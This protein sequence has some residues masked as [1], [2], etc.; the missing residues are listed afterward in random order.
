MTVAANS[1]GWR[2]QALRWL[3]HSAGLFAT[4]MALF[5]L[6]D[7]ETAPLV[8]A[9]G[10]LAYISVWLVVLYLRDRRGPRLPF[11]IGLLQSLYGLSV[12][13]A[14]FGLL[15]LSIVE[16]TI[17]AYL[18]ITGGAEIWNGSMIG[19]IA[20]AAAFI[21]P[22]ILFLLLAP[23]LA[24]KNGGPASR[25][26]EGVRV[27]GFGW[28]QINWL[29]ATAAVAGM[30]GLGAVIAAPP[31]LL[32]VEFRRE[33]DSA[34]TGGELFAAYPVLPFALLAVAGILALG[35]ILIADR[36]TDQAAMRAYVDGAPGEPRPNRRVRIALGGLVACACAASMLMLLYPLHLS[37]ASRAV[38]DGRTALG[39][40]AEAIETLSKAHKNG[41]LTSADF[42]ATLNRLGYWSPDRPEAGLGSLAADAGQTFPDTCTV[43]LAAGTIEPSPFIGVEPDVKFCVAVACAAPFTWSTPPTLLMASSH[44]SRAEG[45][46]EK[47]Y[48]AARAEG[49]PTPPGGYCTADGNLAGNFKG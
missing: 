30:L 11:K 39:E 32:E 36:E 4:M 42:A 18:P 19:L 24:P 49:R 7:M 35:N 23:R 29:S 3:L 6:V 10:G 43:R 9:G 13:I 47:L 1:A 45:W 34:V 20:I 46:Q 12:P 33:I 5:F 27:R 21:Y 15:L 48:V 44:A 25:Y 37:M 26:L 31:V 8:A 16:W 22:P 2:R 41:G 38:R 40:V 17:W 28:F 14:V